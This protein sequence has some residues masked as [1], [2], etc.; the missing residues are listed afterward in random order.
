MGFRP[1][2]SFDAAI[3]GLAIVAAIMGFNSGLLRS[4][5]TILGYVAATPVALASA[6]YVARVMTDQFHLPPVRIWMVFFG[7]FLV[8]GMALGALLRTAVGEMVGPSVSIPDRIAG[9]LLGTVRIGLLAVLM[10]LIFDRIIPANRQP[11]FL[12]ESRLR[13]ILSMAGQQGLRS[14]PPDVTDF[15]DQLKRE[16]GI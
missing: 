2:N 6:P 16:R 1:M 10:V 9:S 7:I 3:C 14:L 8:A 12:A 11:A 5:A 13:P 4:M 15:V